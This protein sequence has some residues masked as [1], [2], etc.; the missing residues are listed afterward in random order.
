MKTIIVVMNFTLT[1]IIFFTIYRL[2]NYIGSTG[3]F[4]YTLALS[5]F[6]VAVV[7]FNMKDHEFAKKVEIACH[8]IICGYAL[9]TGIFL[10]AHQY[11]NV[12][13]YGCWIN[14]SPVE[15]LIDDDVD[16]QRGGKDADQYQVL[17]PIVPFSISYVATFINMI[18][19]TCKVRLQKKKSDR[20]RM[21]RSSLPRQDTQNDS[22]GRFTLFT[23]KLASNYS[24]FNSMN[25]KPG[26]KNNK[27]IVDQLIQTNNNQ[28]ST[29]SRSGTS[30]DPLSFNLHKVRDQI[31]RESYSHDEMKKSVLR[32]SISAKSA[33]SGAID[34]ES[35]EVLPVSSS[36]RSRPSS[37]PKEEDNDEDSKEED[38]IVASHSIC[39]LGSFILC[40][41]F[42][43]IGARLDHEIFVI[44]LL[45]KIFFPLYGFLFI[46][47]YSRPYANDLCKQDP[48]LSR[49]KAFFIVLLRSGGDDD[50]VAGTGST[51][52]AEALFVNNDPSGID[53]PRLTEDE[54][55]KRQEKIRASYRRTFVGLST[56][57][58]AK[59][60]ILA[61][62]QA[63][64]D[65]ENELSSS[66]DSDESSAS[67]DSSCKEDKDTMFNS[68]LD[69]SEMSLQIIK[70][71]ANE[72]TILETLEESDDSDNTFESSQNSLKIINEIDIDLTAHESLEQEDSLH[73]VKRNA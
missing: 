32:S 56:D 4:L 24:S 72:P 62:Q 52:N 71:A 10:L 44:E 61:A 50:G 27:T 26:K 19:V 20:W 48:S 17:F 31:R 64:A 8:V 9:S 2:F 16:C 67:D 36:L 54:R 30:N 69:S 40:Y 7:I 37:V 59:R 5:I 39:Y 58:I 49:I 60:A 53:V 65:M 29:K 35:Q 6:Y 22:N 68:F 1:K 45:S 63:K 25:K 21:R 41:I 73:V 11:F 13:K 34:I 3:S 46:L 14:A 28:F 66:S 33:V 51:R 42:P 70:E 57:A 12:V 23:H 47:M 38:S 43:I 55:T 15:C 18:L